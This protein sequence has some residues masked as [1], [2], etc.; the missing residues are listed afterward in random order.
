MSDVVLILVAVVVLAAAA[1]TVMRLRVWYYDRR[2]DRQYR[3]R[4]H[5]ETVR[6]LLRAE[7]SDRWWEG[8]K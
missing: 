2:G 7:C 1:A 3:E 8:Q 5:L 4:C 6:D